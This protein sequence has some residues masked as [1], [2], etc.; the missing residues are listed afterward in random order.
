MI[1]AVEIV[2]Y[3]T[4][5]GGT[6]GKNTFLSSSNSIYVITIYIIFLMLC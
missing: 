3:E 1:T 4:Y 6:Q 2:A 5:T